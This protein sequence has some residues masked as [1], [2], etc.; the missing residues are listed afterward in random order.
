MELSNEL[1][2]AIELGEQVLNMLNFMYNDPVFN[3]G[4]ETSKE[5][6][7]VIEETRA[8]LIVWFDLTEKLKA[9]DES[10]YQSIAE[11]TMSTFLIN[12]LVQEQQ[13]RIGNLAERICRG[14][15]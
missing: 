4:S 1:K 12:Q 9:V 10:D 11:L 5:I 15:S 7:S 6:K 14:E 8:L 3:D 2:N 13:N